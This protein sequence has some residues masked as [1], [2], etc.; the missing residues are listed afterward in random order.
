MG[1]MMQRIIMVEYI[2]MSISCL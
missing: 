2:Q 1:E